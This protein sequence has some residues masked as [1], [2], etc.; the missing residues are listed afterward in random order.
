MNR[1]NAGYRS[2]FDRPRYTSQGGYNDNY[3]MDRGLSTG[4][5][6]RTESLFTM[7]GG[8]RDM[9][10]GYR[11]TNGSMQ[12]QRGDQSRQQQTS[13]A[14]RGPKGYRRSD[15]RILEDVNE[16]LSRNPELDASEIEVKVNNGEVTLS[17]TVSERQFKRIAEEVA[18]HCSGVEDVRNEIRF[19]RDSETGGNSH[20]Q[21]KGKTN[22]ASAGGR[23]PEA[24]SA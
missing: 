22:Q 2:D 18:E 4:T 12:G 16:A 6:Y 14:G 1:G 23:I 24:K 7:G 17:G 8:N 9:G 20:S 5:N 15:D 10:S 13:Y 21:M 19:Q 3:D 11:D